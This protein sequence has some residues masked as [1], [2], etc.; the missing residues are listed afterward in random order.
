M[1]AIAPLFRMRNIPLRR[2][3]ARRFHVFVS[4]GGLR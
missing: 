4:E 3:N 2:E 1:K